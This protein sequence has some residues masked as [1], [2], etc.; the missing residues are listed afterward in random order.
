M[1]NLSPADLDAFV[2]VAETGS[3]RQ[4]AQA[5]GVSQPT[6]S[7]RIRHLE[8]VLGVRTLDGVDC[9]RLRICDAPQIHKLID[10]VRCQRPHLLQTARVLAPK[11]ALEP[12]FLSSLVEDRAQAGDGPRRAR[13]SS[14]VARRSSLVACSL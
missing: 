4:A 14:L 2:A 7:A 5:L 8:A 13:H 9:S 12:R 6:I 3:F 11:D 10:A 1:I